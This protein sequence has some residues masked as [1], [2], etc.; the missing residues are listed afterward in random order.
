MLKQFIE[1][2]LSL[3]FGHTENSLER[4]LADCLGRPVSL[5]LTE[6]STSMLSARVR[7]GVI[8]VRLHRMFMNADNHVMKEIVLFLKNS[9]GDMGRFRQFLR[10]NRWQLQKR[11]PKK[12]SART[13]GRFHDLRELFD[14]ING[15]YFGGTINSVITWGT[16]SSRYAVRKRTLGSYS[17]ASNVIR[18]NPVLDKKHVPRYFV[19]FVVYHEMLH[20]A[21]GVSKQGERRVCHSREFRNRERLFKDY[22]RA[23]AWERR[24]A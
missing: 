24:T 13:G 15:E 9:K 4:Y 8:H 19:A 7:E 2:Q 3:I 1:R 14:E 16:G 5:V 11:P 18:I 17:S 23:M 10:D 6:N 12:V 20:A 22:E 21:V